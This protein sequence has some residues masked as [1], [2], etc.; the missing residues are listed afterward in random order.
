MNDVIKK[1]QTLKEIFLNACEKYSKK[2]FKESRSLCYKILSIDSNYFDALGLLSNISL[3]NRDFKETKSLLVQ[4]LNLQ[5]T[6]ITILNN[7]GTACVELNEFENASKYYEKI[8]KINPKNVNAPY[9]LGLM[10]YRAKDLTKAKNYFEETIKLQKNFALAFLALGNVYLDLKNHEK[11]ISNYKQAIEFNPN[12]IPAYNN[13]GL[14][15]RSLNDI[16]NAIYFYEKVIK[17][18]NNYV[19]AHHNLA[20]AF[21]EIGDIKKSIKSH[22][23][24][25]KHEPENSIHYFYLSELKKDI[26]DKNLKSKIEQILK[27]NKSSKTNIAYG[28]FLLSKYE[29]NSQNYEKDL[30]YLI[31]GHRYFFESKKTK[32]ELGLKYC[33][34][35]TKQI[36]R[37]AKVDDIG[38]KEDNEIK[39]IFII[40]VPRCGSTLVE[41]IIGSGPKK[42]P[43][44][45]ETSILENFINSKILENQSLNLGKVNDI[46]KSLF[47]M[48]RN[49]G[50]L[51]SE[52]NYTF[53]DK[54]LHNFFYLDLIKKIFPNAKII[55]CNRNHLSSIMSI[56]QN[57]LTEISWA[58]ELENIFKYF[59]NYLEII[60]NFKKASAN[61]IYELEYEKLAKNPE[62]ESKKLMDFCD[63]PWDESCLEFY[64]RKDLISKTASNLQIRKAIYKSSIDKYMPYKNYLK[65]YKEKYSWFN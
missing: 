20:L 22:E 26:L 62:E 56:F 49:K 2:D 11:A 18:K 24:A 52:S 46:R 10:A 59:N 36:S 42:L 65:K 16:K 34:N 35:D 41:K 28:N 53:T 43:M 48:Y 54:T 33:F 17:I 14:V 12:L 30:N 32:F 21:K 9:N 45:E 15:Y 7:I 61:F 47:N 25:I 19:N 27:S 29:R 50:L 3:A 13:L 39:P 58:H 38:V 37:E 5:P 40:G 57:N 64:K 51:L 4:A 31:K 60:K 63:L 6:N 1:K 44:G 23:M 55:N 8:I